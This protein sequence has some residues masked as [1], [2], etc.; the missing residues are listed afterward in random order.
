MAIV[1]EGGDN[2]ALLYLK[3]VHNVC[4]ECTTPRFAWRLALDIGEQRSYSRALSLYVDQKV[5][6][7]FIL[8][9][10]LLTEVLF[11]GSSE[12]ND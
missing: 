6:N 1:L 12:F 5:L 2:E 8:R 11:K 7:H 10:V 4:H 3:G 9:Y